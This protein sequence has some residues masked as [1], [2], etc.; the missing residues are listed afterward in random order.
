MSGLGKRVGG[1]GGEVVILYGSSQ[2][3]VTGNSDLDDA[4]NVSTCFG[5]NSSLNFIYLLS[6][7]YIRL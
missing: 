6:G 3:G 7:T 1:G 5:Q 2:R 4:R